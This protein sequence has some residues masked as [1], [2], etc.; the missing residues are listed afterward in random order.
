[1]IPRIPPLPPWPGRPAPWETGTG[2]G[3]DGQQ[4]IPVLPAPGGW[5]GQT[6]GITTGGPG[7]VP[8]PANGWPGQAFGIA[9]GGPARSHNNPMAGGQQAPLPQGVQQAQPPQGGPQ[10]L[11]QTLVPQGLPPG[12]S[13]QL[14]VRPSPSGALTAQR[15][16]HPDPPADQQQGIPT[17]QP[18]GPASGEPQPGEVQAVYPVL[19]VAGVANP[20]LPT[21]TRNRRYWI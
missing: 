13:A 1:M 21:G 9:N 4:G 16:L 14:R 3:S 18:S 11:Q 2:S 17:P 7:Q 5:P 6:A 20:A 10:Q 12:W 19:P 15:L 8:G